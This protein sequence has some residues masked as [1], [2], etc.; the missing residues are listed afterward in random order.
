MLRRRALLTTL[1]TVL[2]SLTAFTAEA[3]FQRMGVF[4]GQS[5]SLPSGQSGSLDAVCMDEQ[6]DAPSTNDRFTR[7]LHGSNRA[8][9]VRTAR[10]ESATLQQALT[11]GWLRIHGELDGSRKMKIIQEALR[12]GN[13]P[14]LGPDSFDEVVFEN[15]SGTKLTIQVADDVVLGGDTHE[16]FAFNP[17][18]RRDQK[19]NWEEVTESERLIALEKRKADIDRA[20][21]R[22]EITEKAD[23]TRGELFWL[24][25][26]PAQ[27]GKDLSSG[28]RAQV[29]RAETEVRTRISSLQETLLLIGSNV[30]VSGR[31][32][33]QT[34][35]AIKQQQG[36]SGIRE[37]GRID[38]RT[39]RALEGEKKNA[40]DWMAAALAYAPEHQGPLSRETL[41]RAVDLVPTLPLDEGTK[42]AITQR[43]ALPF[44]EF[45][46]Q[47]RRLGYTIPATDN[48]LAWRDTAL[49]FQSDH[50][51]EGATLG[52]FDSNTRTVVDAVV[53]A[54]DQIQTPDLAN[55]AAL[56]PS[57][58]SLGRVAGNDYT[59]FLRV[60]KAAANQ[61]RVN[62]N[63]IVG[64]EALKALAEGDEYLD[65][66]VVDSAGSAIDESVR[67]LLEL[68]RIGTGL[69]ASGGMA[70]RGVALEGQQT[71][72]TASDGLTFHTSAKTAS[73][74]VEM[75]QAV[76][77][78]KL[79][80]TPILSKKYLRTAIGGAT[81][82]VA[83]GPELD[84]VHIERLVKAPVVRAASLD[85]TPED[86]VR[87]ATRAKQRAL[88]LKRT[89]ALSGLPKNV[90]ESAQ[91]MEP[92]ERSRMTPE[93]RQALDKLW[94]DASKQLV[95]RLKDSGIR[96]TDKLDQR[97]GDA[98]DLLIVFAHSDGE[99]LYLPGRKRPRRIGT[100]ELS[101]FADRFRANA[102]TVLLLACD[103]GR[104]DN[105]ARLAAR[106]VSL[107]AGAVIA[108]R[109][110]VGLSAA[111]GFLAQVMDQPE[112]TSLVDRVMRAQQASSAF[113]GQMRMVVFSKP[114]EEAAPLEF[115]TAQR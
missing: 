44:A 61:L 85:R 32:D 50:R 22:R 8:T 60:P 68:D 55:A 57:I 26:D 104:L 109:D 99:S 48:L 101:K 43:L 113:G 87:L 94:V 47:L 45:T 25:E 69:A 65:L 84:G 15:T 19:L 70:L 10:G 31:Y 63:R 49:L 79:R 2:L 41:L 92:Q 112:G 51:I 40:T 108:P 77:G 76:T 66:L 52:A 13:T 62:I 56:D 46:P 38:A 114:G 96:V 33:G 111:E 86:V 82:V 103:T 93:R 72:V 35:R 5:L 89:V 14:A 100:A 90:K 42:A 106:L 17:S 67:D 11:R 53:G 95:A 78:K 98:S 64:R 12:R 9:V 54:M 18:V 16:R 59:M 83:V 36:R 73:D 4:G 39:R 97:L 81:F 6:S 3:A 102:P 115:M 1:L 23:A 71:L 34:Q 88:D 58:V 24:G 107:G 7:V 21:E 105:S 37:S 80:S 30:T 75:T 27:L 28:N 20:R 91:L 110:P 29:E 74:V